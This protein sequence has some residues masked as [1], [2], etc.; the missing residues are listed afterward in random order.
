MA[1]D[2]ITYQEK[3]DKFSELPTW[4]DGLSLGWDRASLAPVAPLFTDEPM[5]QHVYVKKLGEEVVGEMYLWNMNR[6]WEA[7]VKAAA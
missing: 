5:F 7:L 3:V 1:Q 6:P 4:T 2:G